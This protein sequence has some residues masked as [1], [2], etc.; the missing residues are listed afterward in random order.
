MDLK[1]KV[2][3]LYEDILEPVKSRK[4]VILLK[5]VIIDGETDLDRIKREIPIREE[6]IKKYIYDDE[7]M[8]NYLTLDELNIFRDKM[9]KILEPTNKLKRLINLV[10]EKNETDLEKIERLTPITVETIKKYIQ[11]KDELL[12]YLNPQQLEIFLSR[13]ELIVEKTNKKI[14]RL[15]KV[16]LKDGETDLDVIEKKANIKII[17][18]KKH[19]DNPTELKNYLNEEELSLLLS[20]LNQMFDERNNR[21]HNEELELAK[22]IIHDIFNTRYTIETICRQNFIVIT[23]FKNY[24]Y[25]KEYMDTHFKEGTFEKVKSKI[26]EN[27]IIRRKRPR[28]YFVIEDEVCIRIAQD[29]TYYLNQ[30]DNRKLNFVAYYLGTGANLELLVKHFGTNKQEIL[31][32]LASPKL[33]EILK[34]E[35]YTVLHEY[36]SIENLLLGNNLLVKKQMVTEIV[37]FLQQNNFDTVLAMN[38]FRIPEP[39]FNKILVE[40]IKLPYADI[41][42][43]E[44]IKGIL[45]SEPEKKIK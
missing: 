27:K 16:V 12:K 13:M 5:Y 40:I 2:M 21:V 4:I 23:K 28:D 33:K 7:L 18:I 26:E 9:N 38:H 31:S 11:N 41:Q 30:F 24:F 45:N 15:I 1:N 35:Y 34:P 43:R 20:K 10:L 42:T 17:T 3:K 22:K 29:D 37:E 32:T 14:E 44:T 36:L 6:T 8:L 39:L 25:T 19:V